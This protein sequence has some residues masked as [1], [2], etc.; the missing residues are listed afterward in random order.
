MTI[1]SWTDR[2]LYFKDCAVKATYVPQWWRKL[3]I[4]GQAR[5]IIWI[6]IN[7]MCGWLKFSILLRLFFCHLK[8]RV[9]SLVTKSRN[10]IDTPLIAYLLY[11]K[12]LASTKG[13]HGR[14]IIFHLF[15]CFSIYCNLTYVIS[16]TSPKITLSLLVIAC[17]F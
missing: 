8:Q 9:V 5:L 16:L 10:Y 7:Y 2:C 6:I 14:P 13:I 1:C 4:T 3:F 11:K 12:C 15:I 17:Y